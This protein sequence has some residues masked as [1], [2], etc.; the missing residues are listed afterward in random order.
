MASPSSGTESAPQGSQEIPPTPATT[1]N[2]APFGGGI[3]RAAGSVSFG[4]MVSRVLGL[5]REQVLAYLFP[6]KLGLDAFYAAFRIPN[7]L[8]DMFGEG[9]L[10]KAF[11]TTFSEIQEKEG[12]Q[13]AFR[14]ASLVLNALVLVVGTLTFLGIVYADVIVDVVV[15]GEG[16]DVAFDPATSYGFTGKRELTVY[17]TRVMFP[18]IVLVAGAALVMG[19]LN[20]RGRF[21]VPALASSCFNVGSIVVGVVGY[22]VGPELGYHPTVGMAVGVLAGGAL[23]LLWQL[24][25]LFRVGYRYAATLSLRDPRLAKVVRLFVPGAV[26]AST[27]QVNVLINTI[28]ASRGEGWLAWILQ[29]FRIVHLPLGLV[30]VAVS[31]ATLPALSRAVARD[32]R[33]GFRDTFSLATR[34]VILFTVPAAVGLIVI[35]DPI[36]RLIFEQGEF[37]PADTVA[38]AA[39][40]R[41]YSIG[42]LSFSA[43][44]IVTDGFYALQDVRAPLLVSFASMA[45]NAFLNWLFVVSLGMDHR[46]LALATSITATLSFVGLWFLFRRRSR[47]GRLDTR[48]AAA[49]LMKTLGASSVMGVAAFYT[50][51][52]LDEWFGHVAVWAR[53]LQVGAA[54]FVGLGVY[55]A[56]CRVLGVREM[57]QLGW[58]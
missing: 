20:A 55:L 10:S 56:G 19:I 24:P 46:G 29:S 50:F 3:T 23:Q 49:T 51:R 52:G 4:V 16:F 43:V 37:G 15:P 11:V 54:T 32:D 36:V 9:A 38:V 25:T 5:V 6:A 47:M 42:L 17:L 13:E 27:V 26:I 48:K 8:R 33:E 57:D 28:F 58:R 35:A 39:A 34:L 21:F 41:Y 7:L 1:A 14:L 22:L 18:F 40:L 12:E 45:S 30:G 2:G 53:L 44:K 31:V